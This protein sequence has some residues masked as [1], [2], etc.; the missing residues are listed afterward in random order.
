[1]ATPQPTSRDV[2]RRTWLLSALRAAAAPTLEVGRVLSLHL[3]STGA[4]APSGG[5]GCSAGGGAAGARAGGAGG[6]ATSA[7]GGSSV[8]SAGVAARAPTTRADDRTR[9]MRWV[10]AA[11]GWENG[12]PKSTAPRR[13]DNNGRRSGDMRRR[14]TV[15]A[16][17]RQPGRPPAGDALSPRGE[18]AA[19]SC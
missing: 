10:I 17:D 6:G 2:P 16:D 4:R 5:A 12:P 8:A 11:P 19:T 18:A 9:R 15:T 13:A 3:P 7:G 14:S 1:M